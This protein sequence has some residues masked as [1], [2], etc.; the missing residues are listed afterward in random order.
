[1]KFRVALLLFVVVTIALAVIC[2]LF[3]FS[4]WW[5]LFPLVI[6]K[7]LLIYGSAVI[8]HDFYLKAYHFSRTQEKKIAITFD[9]GP[10]EIITPQVL[11]TLSDYQAKASFFVIGKNIKGKEHILKQAYDKGHVIGSHSFSHSFFIDFK[12]TKGFLEEFEQSA[13]EIRKVT[14]K[15]PRLFRPPYGVTTPNIASAVKKKGLDVIGWSIRSFDTTK[16]R[17]E[18]IF[19]RIKD[20]LKPGSILLLHDT[21]EKS[22]SVLRQTLNFAQKNGFKFVGVEDLLNIQ[23]YE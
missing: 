15:S 8:Q 4:F 21:S 22:L 2:Y 12:S 11:N 23:A 9:D 14:G 17:E 1:M 6:F 10:D 7:A 19:N 3:N 20:Q 18:V 5:L 13:N 16:D